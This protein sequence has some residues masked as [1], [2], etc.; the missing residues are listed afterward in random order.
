MDKKKT[1]PSTME[2][3]GIGDGK[4]QF[5]PESVHRAFVEEFFRNRTALAVAHVTLI[6]ADGNPIAYGDTAVLETS[7]D[8][9]KDGFNYETR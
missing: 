3:I 4:P 8:G 2:T 5:I 9:R 1:S 7:E 6:G